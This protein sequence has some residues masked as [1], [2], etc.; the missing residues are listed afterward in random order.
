MDAAIKAETTARIAGDNTEITE[1]ESA[2]TALGVRIDTEVAERLQNASDLDAAIKAETTARIAGDNAEITARGNADIVLQGNIDTEVQTRNAS[3]VAIRADL[4]AEIQTRNASDVAIRA[5]LAALVDE[6]AVQVNGDQSIHDKK[7]FR[8]DVQL[9]DD[10]ND[11]IEIRGHVTF[12]EH[13][14]TPEF[15]TGIIVDGD[16]ALTGKVTINKD[17]TNGQDEGFVS[18]IPAYFSQRAYVMPV[19]STAKM[20]LS[21]ADDPDFTEF[22]LEVY[23]PLLSDNKIYCDTGLIDGVH[24]E[25]GNPQS[26]DCDNLTDENMNLIHGVVRRAQIASVGYLEDHGRDEMMFALKVLYNTLGL[27]TAQFDSV[28]A[29]YNAAK[30]NISGVD[31]QHPS[32]T[33]NQLGEST[34]LK[35]A[36]AS[37]GVNCNV[38]ADGSAMVAG[39]CEPGCVDDGAGCAPSNELFQN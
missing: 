25:D 31:G 20:T 10:D 19:D 17:D 5:E 36:R 38:N 35:F 18:N 16:T 4:A 30:S 32:G 28:L 6:G 24:F 34:E 26:I 29:A 21:L 37:I 14:P 7:T 12:S 2:D 13:A 3:D 39:S 23:K 11:E 27:S 15:D 22:D 1:R 9:G 8:G 33:A